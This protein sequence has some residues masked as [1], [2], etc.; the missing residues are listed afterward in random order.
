MNMMSDITHF[1]VI[2]HILTRM[3]VCEVASTSLVMPRE[4]ERMKER[5]RVREREKERARERER[6]R[7]RGERESE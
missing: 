7:E 2:S 4:R 5:E 1:G 3:C 6:V